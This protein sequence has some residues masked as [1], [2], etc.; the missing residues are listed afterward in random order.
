MSTIK[1]I[2]SCILLTV[3]LLCSAPLVG[4]SEAGAK[5]RRATHH[6][7][8]YHRSSHRYYTNT[9]GRR[10]HVP[11]YSKSAPAAIALVRAGEARARIMVACEGGCDHCCN[12]TL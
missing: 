9:R 11:V 12:G 10:V 7:R 8:T 2:I 4:T 6:S 3:L 1:R 5:Q